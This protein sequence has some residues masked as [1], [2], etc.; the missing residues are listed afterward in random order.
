MGDRVSIQ[1][2]KGGERSV[3]LFDHWGGMS[4]VAKAQKYAK[5]LKILASQQ[6]NRIYPLTRLEPNTVMLDYI[7]EIALVE[8]NGG[9]KR[10]E[11]SLYLGAT[12]ND[13]DNFDNGHHVIKLD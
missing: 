3:V 11:N 12:E 6:G 13:G 4:R 1:F 8:F 9:K 5:N 2:E 10:I 7:R